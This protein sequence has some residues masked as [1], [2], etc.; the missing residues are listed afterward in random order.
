[1]KRINGK[2]K[3]LL[4]VLGFL[5]MLH[6]VPLITP[7]DATDDFTYPGINGAPP[8]IELLDVSYSYDIQTY[9]TSHSYYGLIT[10]TEFDQ[11]I[12]LEGPKKDYSI[13]L[14]PDYVLDVDL[15]FQKIGLYCPVFYLEREPW[16]SHEFSLE[17]SGS[18]TLTFKVEGGF[19]AKKGPVSVGVSGS[20]E[21]STTVETSSG[22]GLKFDSSYGAAE[23]VTVYLYMEFLRVN[24]TVTFDG[25]EE[26]EYD[27]ILL[28]RIDFDDFHHVPDALERPDMNTTALLDRDGDGPDYFTDM[29]DYREHTY[30]ETKDVTWGL[31]FEIKIGSDAFGLSME[32]SFECS[33][34]T[35]LSLKHRFETY[36]EGDDYINRRKLPTS[37]HGFWVS[38]GSFFSINL[39]MNHTEAFAPSPPTVS[40]PSEIDVY[41]T[42]TFSATSTDPLGR[43]LYYVFRWGDGQKTVTEYVP[44]GTKVTVNHTYTE[45]GH[46]M[47]VVESRNYYGEANDQ[48]QSLDVLRLEPDRPAAPIGPSTGLQGVSYGF[49]MVTDDDHDQRLRYEI[50]WGD[51]TVEQTGFVPSGEIVTLDHA[52]AGSVAG[53]YYDVTVRAQNEINGRW[54]DLSTPARI[55]IQ[56]SVPGV[57]SIGGDDSLYVDAAGNFWVQTIEPSGLQMRY[58]FHFSDGYSWSSDWVD[59]GTL[60]R[61]SHAFSTPGTELFW[62]DAT[63]THTVTSTC[64]PMTISV[65]ENVA[66]NVPS[67]PQGPSSGYEGLSYS[68]SVSTADVD[69]DNIRYEVAWGDGTTTLSDYYNSGDAATLQHAWSEGSLGG[70]AYDVKVRAQDSLGHWSDWSSA[71]QIVIGYSTPNVPSISA[72]SSLRVGASGTFWAQSVDP[73][74]VHIRYK[75][76][77]SDGATWTS[78][79]VN[80][81]TSVTASHAFSSLGTKSFWVEVTNEFGQTSTADPKLF[82]VY[83]SAPNRPNTPTGPSSGY[84]GKYYTFSFVTTDPEG[85]NVRYQID[86]GD[87]STTTTGYYASGS[88]VTRSHSWSVS[89][90]GGMYYYVKVRAQDVYGAWSSWSSSLRILIKPSS[91]GGPIITSEPPLAGTQINPNPAQFSTSI[92]NSD[93]IVHTILTCGIELY[94]VLGLR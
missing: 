7:V 69:D 3:A 51:G 31:G 67:T 92:A 12:C 19:N 34:S 60:V 63:N 6:T 91:G 62:A 57:P 55:M 1:M 82:S 74:G 10:N 56:R 89:V 44:S 87:G 86:W 13:F 90:S 83:N 32:G 36:W 11:E 9:H 45:P 25:N 43:D 35:S 53:I 39:R 77:W 37:V 28:E 27:A 48:L 23:Y 40:I 41:E 46:R 2:M 94:A 17:T 59:S 79:W 68:F 78:A 30:Y 4:I 52:W 84:T 93:S 21:T 29:G 47:I 14:T 70:T 72:P 5:V 66:P 73:A 18:E 80:S 33:T 61:V 16:Y 20:Y 15:T 38:V 54:S 26:R 8:D 71:K 75:F 49:S 22:W 50:D 85:H 88:T 24:G 65:R 42:G 64:D 81:G 58:T 76:Y